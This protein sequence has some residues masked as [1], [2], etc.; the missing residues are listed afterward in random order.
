MPAHLPFFPR[1]FVS[2]APA[3]PARRLACWALA[4]SL[5]ACGGGGGGGGGTDTGSGSSTPPVLS[6]V[7]ATGAP[8]GSARVTVLDA[9]GAT[10]GTGST[11]PADGSYKITLSKQNPQAPLL[12]EVRGLSAQ[13]DMV[14]LHSAVP[15]AASAMVANVSPLSEAL[16]ALTLGHAPRT[17]FKDVAGNSSAV[18]LISTQLS[19]AADF[20]KTLIKTNIGDAKITDAAT[21][22]LL[23][24]ASF[25]ANKGPQD[26]L[27]ESLR[28]DLGSSSAG[29]PQLVLANK[30][31]PGAPEEV[32]VDLPALK[33]ELAKGSSAAPLNAVTST[34]K[35]TS[36]ASTVLP[37]AASLD[38]L[39]A[40]L[41]KMLAQG[42]SASAISTHSLLSAFTVN[43]SR[44]KVS[45]AL[46]FADLASKNL[47]LG[48]FQLVACLD[49]VLSS[50][51]CTRVQVSAYVTDSTGKVLDIF[52]TTVNYLKSTTAGVPSWRLYGNG[53]NLEFNVLPV[54]VASFGGDGSLQAGSAANPRVGVQLDLQGQTLDAPITGALDSGVVQTPNGFAIAMAYCARP[55]MCISKIPGATSTTATGQATDFALL[56]DSVGWIGG[57]DALRAA[58]YSTTFTQTGGTPKTQPAFLRADV[59][60]SPASSRFP[61]IDDLSSSSVLLGRQ[62][63]TGRKYSWAKWAEANPDMRMLSIRLVQAAS[64]G[65][66]S[67]RELKLA[68]PVSTEQALGASVLPGGLTP[69]VSELWLVAADSLGRRYYSRF[70]LNY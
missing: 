67:L 54:A 31:R 58:K 41:N 6:G 50:G 34:L 24:D 4:L 18:A 62:L 10:V 51:N 56:Q 43:D 42:L 38:E 23:G 39:P 57:A 14:L 12:V 61:M 17:V 15:K 16:L 30:L 52:Q 60:A 29:V 37:N 44:D 13:G 46:Y 5:A 55:R 21:L 22:D 8:L 40:A 28:V 65:T 32:V 26:L 68:L 45:M 47:Q 11:H 70:V 33:T 3:R 66:P 69:T 35:A 53:R 7:A 2:A 20:L 19:A 48:R 36:G 49:D 9:S 25:A 59:P 64:A 63:V 27:V 1:S